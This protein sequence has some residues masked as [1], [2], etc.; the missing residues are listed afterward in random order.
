MVVGSLGEFIFRSDESGSAVT[1]STI[2]V[3]RASKVVSHS[4][5]EGDPVVDYAGNDSDK[6]TLTGVLDASFNADLDAAINS[7]RALQDGVP[8]AFTRGT[9]C[10]GTFIVQSF[11]YSEDAWCGAAL[12]RATWTMLLISTRVML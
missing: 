1:F 4:T 7:L 12:Q 8:R 10:Y 3:T 11:D 5:I 2:R 9:H 6:I